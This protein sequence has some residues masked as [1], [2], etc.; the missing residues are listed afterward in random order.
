MAVSEAQFAQGEVVRDRVTGRDV[1]V[2]ERAPYTIRNR[3]AYVVKFDDEMQAARTVDEL[4]PCSGLT[5][6]AEDILLS[7]LAETD[8]YVRDTPTAQIDCDYLRRLLREASDAIPRK[9]H[10]R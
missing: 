5:Q 6:E 9:D 8:R 7:V 2:V 4:E 10:T 1:L 3:P